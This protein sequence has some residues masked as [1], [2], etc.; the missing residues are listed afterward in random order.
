MIIIYFI[1]GIKMTRKEF[2]SMMCD[3]FY[4]ENKYILDDPSKRI[5]MFDVVN[6]MMAVLGKIEN[7]LDLPEWDEEEIIPDEV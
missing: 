1:K 5:N 2:I 4:K 3:E 6:G 7:T